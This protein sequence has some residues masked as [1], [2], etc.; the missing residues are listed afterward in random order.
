MLE[1]PPRRPPAGRGARA[2]G[3]RQAQDRMAIAG[4]G[5]RRKE[6]GAKPEEARAHAARDE[7]ESA[8]AQASKE[9]RRRR[10]TCVRRRFA[11]RFSS[12]LR[13]RVGPAPASAQHHEF[14]PD[15][16]GLT[17]RARCACWTHGE[18]GI[19]VWR[20]IWR[21][22]DRWLAWWI[23]RRARWET[24]P[25]STAYRCA[26]D[27]LSARFPI[28]TASKSRSADIWE[29]CD[30]ALSARVDSAYN[31][32][33]LARAHAV[34]PALKRAVLVQVSHKVSSNHSQTHQL[35]FAPNLR[36]A[37]PRTLSLSPPFAP[38]RPGGARGRARHENARQLRSAPQH[39]RPSPVPDQ[40]I[41]IDVGHG[42]RLTRHRMRSYARRDASVD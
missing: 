20:W 17:D 40:Q 8:N 28:I 13:V 9:T 21:R 10:A 15:G 16:L 22:W 25:T 29:V 31:L 14:A 27:F 35:F 32:S 4:R 38:T 1:I 34:L 5:A 39:L 26:L 36:S 42:A 12:S 7:N 41:A 23:G 24:R 3:R 2:L 6:G 30:H 19:W 11:L 18:R 37:A 33:S